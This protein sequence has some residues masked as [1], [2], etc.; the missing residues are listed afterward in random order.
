MSRPN[1]T[2]CVP[3]IDENR[4]LEV[5]RIRIALEGLAARHA[6]AGLT[7]KLVRELERINEQLIEADEAK[8]YAALRTLNWKFHFTI[9]QAARMPLL[10]KMIENCWLMIGS[11]LNVLYPEYGKVNVGIDIHRDI[12]EAVKSKDPARLEAAIAE[13]IRSSSEWLASMIRSR[14]TAIAENA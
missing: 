4:L 2:V 9:Y 3:E 6:A 11:Y 14:A 12:I 8:D 5:S 10:S 1:G 13:D 7:S